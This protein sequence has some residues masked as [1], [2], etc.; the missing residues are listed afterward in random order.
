MGV[1]I[2]FYGFSECNKMVDA[3][4]KVAAACN[5]VDSPILFALEDVA[6]A[7]ECCAAHIGA[8]PLMVLVL[9]NCMFSSY[10]CISPHAACIGCK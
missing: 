7:V 9:D 10:W 2:P 6:C 4:A 8:A 3:L 5:W 1:N